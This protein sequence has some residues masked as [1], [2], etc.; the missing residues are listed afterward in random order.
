MKL[1]N[2][3]NFGNP[4]ETLSN[5]CIDFY[6]RLDL[7]EVGS[8]VDGAIDAAEIVYAL[9]INQPLMATIKAHNL[10]HHASEIINLLNHPTVKAFHAEL[11]DVETMRDYFA[12]CA[13][14]DFNSFEDLEALALKSF[15]TLVN[16]NGIESLREKIVNLQGSWERTACKHH[17][18]DLNKMCAYINTILDRAN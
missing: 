6:G 9:R 14:M 17:V 15:N 16:T 13:L 11:T 3:F 5:V 7:P 10:E 4:I 1:S 2:G 12:E 8:A 18:D